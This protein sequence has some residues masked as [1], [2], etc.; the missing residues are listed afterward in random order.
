MKTKIAIWLSD[1]EIKSLE[2]FTKDRSEQRN[3]EFEKAKIHPSRY[4]ELSR[5]KGARELILDRLNWLG[6]HEGGKE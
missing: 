3:K 1:E 4:G 5:S 6:Y 2:K